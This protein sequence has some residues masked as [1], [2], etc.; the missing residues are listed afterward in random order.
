MPPVPLE[1]LTPPLPPISPIPPIPLALGEVGSVL[2]EAHARIAAGELPAW[3]SVVASSQTAGRGQLRRHWHSP[4]GNIYAALHVPYVQPFVGSEAAPALGGLVVLALQELCTRQG[5]AVDVRLK[6]PND[7]VC[8]LQGA[9]R[10][11]GGI[12]LEERHGC[13]VA[14]MGI[15]VCHALPRELLRQGYAMP[16][17]CLMDFS[18]PLLLHEKEQGLSPALLAGKLWLHLVSAMYFWYTKTFHTPSSW[19]GLAEENLLWKNRSV[20]LSDGQTEGEEI[21]GTLL[22]LAPCGGVRLLVQGKENV[23]LNGSLHAVS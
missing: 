7:V 12:L 5:G 23:F 15:N 17:T 18:I 13:L 2:D 10:K 14:G 20:F 16:A 19:L 4:E 3:G 8:L 22:G 11:V 9:P 21:R 1:S 6:W